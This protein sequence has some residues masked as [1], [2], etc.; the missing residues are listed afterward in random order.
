MNK[1]I[2]WA[3]AA[4]NG[5]FLSIIPI[6]ADYIHQ[7]FQIEGTLGLLINLLKVAGC[8]AVLHYFIKKNFIENNSEL[9]YGNSFRY[10]MAVSLF[11]TVVCTLATLVLYQVIIPGQLEAQ[12]IQMMV[13]YEEMG[14]EG[15]AD[16]DMLMRMMPVTM[17]I[18]QIFNCIIWG[19]ILSSILANSAKVKKDN[20]FQ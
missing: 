18:G 3:K 16:Y 17:T 14:I 2:D 4:T 8:T 20:P 10:G 1:K 5:L 6:A 13:M 12:V 11:S 7:I 19:L 9:T 15:L